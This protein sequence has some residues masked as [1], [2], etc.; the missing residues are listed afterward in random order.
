[1]K[2]KSSIQKD[3]MKLKKISSFVLAGTIALTGL[4]F[5]AA[6]ANAAPVAVTMGTQNIVNDNN[7]QQIVDVFNGINRFRASKGL[8]PV[9]F[10]AAISRNVT[11]PWT[12]HMAATDSFYHNPDFAKNAPAGWSSAGEI[13]A[14]RSDRTG[15]GLVDQWINSPPH[16]T[17]MSDPRSNVISLGVTFTDGTWQ[18]PNRYPMYGTAN[19]YGYNTLPAET[20]N[21][22]QDWVNAVSGPAPAFNDLGGNV[23]VKEITWMKTSGISTGYADGTYRP[24][25]SVNREQMAAF[26][27]RMA[28]K[29]TFTP[30]TVSP[31]ADVPTNHYFYK[32]IAWMHASGISTGWADKTY[33][34]FDVVNREQMAAFIKRFTGGHCS[35]PSAENYVAPANATFND[36]RTSVFYKEIEW[37][38][39]SGVSTGWADGSYRPFAGVTREAMAAFLYRADGIIDSNGGCKP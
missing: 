38:K 36:S 28:G 32:E 17:I 18:T 9:K 31:F 27:Y 7:Y 24:F 11:Q 5:S 13:I 20:Y 14:A 15:Q 21:T 30:P 34:P 8:A 16:N 1:M 4:S 6:P 19:F 2:S 35:V 22:A 12:N 25:D 26:L 29:P 33:R 37:M 3:I 23:F 10:N 39:A